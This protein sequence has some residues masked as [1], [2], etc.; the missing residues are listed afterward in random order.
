MHAWPNSESVGQTLQV[1]QQWPVAHQE[2]MRI[3][4]LGSQGSERSQQHILP[5]H[6]AQSPNGPDD[7]CVWRY[8][9]R[10][11]QRIRVTAIAE[12]FRIDSVG[13]DANLPS[14]DDPVRPHSFGDVLG[15]ATKAIGVESGQSAQPT[16]APPN[17]VVLSM[18]GMDDDG[19][20][21]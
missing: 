16:G 21:G 18:L 17:R 9:E 1:F 19:N 7:R 3:R 8:A 12:A 6:L 2:Q 13:H 5:F 4:D 15:D 14:R 10:L 11:P 20:F